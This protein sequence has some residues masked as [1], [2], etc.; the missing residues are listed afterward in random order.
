MCSCDLLLRDRTLWRL[1]FVTMVQDKPCLM[2]DKPCNKEVVLIDRQQ[3][4]TRHNVAAGKHVRAPAGSNTMQYVLCQMLHL[5][6][7]PKIP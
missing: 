2:Q 7:A 4:L 3:L 5:T 1:C 6:L